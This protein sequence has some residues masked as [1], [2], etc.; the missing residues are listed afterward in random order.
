MVHFI[1]FCGGSDFGKRLCGPLT[2]LS[3]TLGGG[4]RQFFAPE[5]VFVLGSSL[6]SEQELLVSQRHVP[7]LITMF[8]PL[9][10]SPIVYFKAAPFSFFIAPVFSSN[11]CLVKGS[12]VKFVFESR[13]F[14][15]GSFHRLPFVTCFPLQSSDREFRLSVGLW[16]T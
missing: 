7:Y 6:T 8:A 5:T 1:R 11:P 14:P 13:R 10:L 12:L 3:F 16:M 2:D 15:D 9:H 4:Y